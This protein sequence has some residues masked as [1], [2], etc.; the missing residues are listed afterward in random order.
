MAGNHRHVFGG[1]SNFVTEF[2]HVCRVTKID[3]SV[4]K[5][6]KN[7]K[8]EKKKVN[9]SFAVEFESVLESTRKSLMIM[10]YQEK[11]GPFLYTTIM[12]RPNLAF[13]AAKLFQS[14]GNSGPER[15][16]AADQAIR[17]LV[18]TI[19]LSELRR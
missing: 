12:R 16:K 5:M 8:T 1:L 7:L 14:L 9:Y 13:A 17:Y 15:M 4:G 10:L 2:V 11:V 6:S 18:L 19:H 3:S